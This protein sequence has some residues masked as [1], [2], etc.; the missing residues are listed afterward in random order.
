MTVKCEFLNNPKLVSDF[1]SNICGGG[2]VAVII[3]MMIMIIFKNI[4]IYICKVVLERFAFYTEFL[5]FCVL[6]VSL[7]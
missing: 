7:E 5:C 2:A 6:S 3:V 4:Y 1:C